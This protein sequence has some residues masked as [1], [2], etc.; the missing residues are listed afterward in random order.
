MPITTDIQLVKDSLDTG[1]PASLTNAHN[2]NMDLLTAKIQEITTLTNT[3]E[4]LVNGVTT[5]TGI[6]RYVYVID[7]TQ[8]DTTTVTESDNT[9]ITRNLNTFTIV[10]TTDLTNAIIQLEDDLGRI[11][12]STVEIKKDSNNINNVTIN[13]GFAI[14]S[15]I[16]V[17]LF[18]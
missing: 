5:S 9:T 3:L 6:Q 12:T 2:V 14:A 8:A 18:N 11:L 17:L 13:L 10:H 16:K 7:Q 15:D 4:G 1:T